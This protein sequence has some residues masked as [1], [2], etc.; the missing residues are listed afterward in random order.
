MSVKNQLAQTW[1]TTAVEA[2]PV[3]P[4][5]AGVYAHKARHNATA[6]VCADAGS[7]K[8]VVQSFT[9]DAQLRVVL[10]VCPLASKHSNIQ[11]DV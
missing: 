4:L 9:F 6:D 7:Y 8:F 1:V 2:C 5:A 3:S 10:I 11:K